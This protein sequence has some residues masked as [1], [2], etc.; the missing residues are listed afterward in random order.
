[1]SVLGKEKILEYFTVY[2]KDNEK[3]NKNYSKFIE[4]I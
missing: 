3:K 2:M 4:F 1:M